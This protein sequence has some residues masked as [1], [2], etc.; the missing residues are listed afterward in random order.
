[1]GSE[2][3][4]RSIAKGDQVMTVNPAV[5]TLNTSA[6]SAKLMVTRRGDDVISTISSNQSVATVNN[7]DQITGEVVVNSVKDTTN[8][9]IITVKMAEEGNY[10]AGADRQV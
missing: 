10:L 7:V 6:R 8:T 2:T 9:I 3:V 5:V 1:M 4:V